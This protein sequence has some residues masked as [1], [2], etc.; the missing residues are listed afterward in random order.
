MIRLSSHAAAVALLSLITTPLL[1]QSDSEAMDEIQKCRQYEDPAQRMACYD[2]IG[3]PRAPAAM[4]VPAEPP[5]P[6]PAAEPVPA[7]QPEPGGTPQPEA[8]PA[9]RA[10]A[11]PGPAGGASTRELTDDIGLPKSEGDYPTIRA[12][13]DRCDYAN[14]RRFYFYFANGQIWKYIGT[15][16]LRFLNCDNQ[17]SLIED[18][19]GFKLQLDGS[20]KQY[21]V[22]R[23]K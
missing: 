2:R 4:T 17:A 15:K 19:F 22:Q 7:A 16:K 14:N 11:A 5:A 21:R 18:G 3:E 10:T 23:V 8:Q 13:V 20:E 1:A 6:A 12:S 9:P